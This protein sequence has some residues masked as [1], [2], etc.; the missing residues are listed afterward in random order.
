MNLG[1]MEGDTGNNTIY[2]SQNEK[3]EKHELLNTKYGRTQ[4]HRFSIGSGRRTFRG[5]GCSEA[6]MSGSALR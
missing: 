6:I 3:P 5:R 4:S 2:S 1:V